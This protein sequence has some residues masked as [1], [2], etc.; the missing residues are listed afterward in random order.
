VNNAARHAFGGGG[1]VLV[2]V[3]VDGATIFYRVSDDGRASSGNPSPGLGRSIVESLAQALGGEVQWRF[4]PRGTSVVL[5]I[6]ADP[7]TLD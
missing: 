7:T 1:R 4:E 2:E 6:P 3:G 5:R